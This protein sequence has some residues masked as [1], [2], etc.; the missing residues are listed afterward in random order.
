MAGN[1]PGDVVDQKE[2]RR[3]VR[4]EMR[5][6]RDNETFKSAI[7]AADKSLFNQLLSMF[8]KAN[9]M[10]NIMYQDTFDKYRATKKK[11]SNMTH[12]EIS[13]YK[14]NNYCP[15]EEPPM[16][17]L[18]YIEMQLNKQSSI[19]ERAKLICLKLDKAFIIFPYTLSKIEIRM[20]NVMINNK[21]ILD[22]ISHFMSFY[23]ENH[24]F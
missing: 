11:M 6:Y 23:L 15:H 22:G 18:K 13:D 16:D 1:T 9:Q 10:L 3:Y 5:E 8:T 20:R 24:H 17:K 12:S 2:R 14:K 21:A 19:L 4:K 7:E